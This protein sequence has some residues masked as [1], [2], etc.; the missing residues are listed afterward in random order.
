MIRVNT[1][2]SHVVEIKDGANF[3]IID[4]TGML[5]ILDDNDNVISAFAKDSWDSV[6][7]DA[8]VLWST[9]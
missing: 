3:Q 4:G 5:V 9:V 1:N 2:F 7:K 8:K 6:F